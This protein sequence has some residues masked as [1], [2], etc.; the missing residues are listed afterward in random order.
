MV[1]DADCPLCSNGTT[2]FAATV[3]IDAGILEL[4]DI[5]FAGDEK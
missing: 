1:A 4:V 3:N 2:T 5:A